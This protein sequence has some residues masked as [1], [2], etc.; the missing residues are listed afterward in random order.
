MASIGASLTR[1]KN[2]DTWLHFIEA[3][4]AHAPSRVPDRAPPRSGPTRAPARCPAARPSQNTPRRNLPHFERPW[5]KYM[6]T[7]STRE[8]RNLTPPER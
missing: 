7:F 2:G 5:A 3:R 6:V 1:R 8:R 4:G